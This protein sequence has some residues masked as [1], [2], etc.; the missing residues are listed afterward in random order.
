MGEVEQ[1]RL[2]VEL[3]DWSLEIREAKMAQRQAQLEELEAK[4]KKRHFEQWREGSGPMLFE[5]ERSH[6]WKFHS[7]TNTA[8]I[9][10]STD[11]LQS[12]LQDHQTFPDPK[13]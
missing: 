7:F 12:R 13:T 8:P 9:W 10:G 6:D 11:T 3:K 1:A 5:T 2:K 4:M